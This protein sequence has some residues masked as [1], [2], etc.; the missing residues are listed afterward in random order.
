VSLNL[1]SVKPTGLA[2]QGLEDQSGGAVDP[3]RTET[4]VLEDVRKASPETVIAR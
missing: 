1:G 4:S 3:Q 2:A